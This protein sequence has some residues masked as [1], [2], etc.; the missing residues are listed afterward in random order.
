[1]DVSAMVD[2]AK[3]LQFGI[4]VFVAVSERN[5]LTRQLVR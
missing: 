3:K 2:T 5:E 1:M 4:V